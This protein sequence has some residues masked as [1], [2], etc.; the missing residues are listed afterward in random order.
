MSEECAM[1]IIVR[2][3][4]LDRYLNAVDIVDRTA[5]VLGATNDLRLETAYRREMVEAINAF[6]R[7]KMP[8]PNSGKWWCSVAE[9][10]HP[11]PKRLERV[12]YGQKLFIRHRE[13]REVGLFFPFIADAEL[14]EVERILG[15]MIED[16]RD[17]LTEQLAGA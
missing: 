15:D 17:R 8:Q 14:I 2:D 16:F 1:R 7:P 9:M 3:A 6:I 4:L 12:V 13:P 10:D 5:D 11:A